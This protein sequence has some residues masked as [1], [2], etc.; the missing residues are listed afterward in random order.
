M[1]QYYEYKKDKSKFHLMEFC[2]YEILH[3][4]KK[5]YAVFKEITRDDLKQRVGPLI[6]HKYI[7]S[8]DPNLIDINRINNYIDFAKVVY[9][10]LND[11][12]GVIS[13]SAQLAS[14]LLM[15]G[16]IQSESHYEEDKSL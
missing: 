3:H 16:S 6:S 13:P 1:N 10:F 4:Y 2:Y 7:S 9:S 8:K 14:D 12:S 5:S 15:L 11:E